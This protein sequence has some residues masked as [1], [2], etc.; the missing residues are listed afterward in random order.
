[1]QIKTFDS[2]HPEHIPLYDQI[3]TLTQPVNNIYPGRT[4]WFWEKF[5]PGLQ[6]KERMY[7]IAQDNDNTLAGC[8]LIKRT[9]EEK[10]ICTL[11]VHPQFRGQGLGRQLM[12]LT[13]RELGE[14]PLIT[15]SSRNLSQLS[16]L[17]KQYGFHLSA[18]KKGAYNSEDTEYYFND[19]KADAIKD[20]LI[21]VLV[22]RMNQLRQR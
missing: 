4:K 2:F 3:L 12:E 20:K 7:I 19:K 9:E 10:K 13:L 6:K 5:I 11:F 15:V 8:V 21:P 17:L 18:T 16:S 22:G 1:M 14:H